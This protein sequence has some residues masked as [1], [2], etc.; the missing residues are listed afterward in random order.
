MLLPASKKTKYSKIY[1]LLNNEIEY[2]LSSCIYAN[3]FGKKLFSVGLGE[4]IYANEPSK[5]EFQGLWKVIQKCNVVERK[6]IYIK[7]K[8]SV[9]VNIYFESKTATIPDYS[10]DLFKAFSKLC[11]H[12]YSSTK[13]LVG[14][15]DIAGESISDHYLS[16]KKLNNNICLI[17]GMEELS[18]ERANI[19]D[20]EQWVSDYDHLLPV[21][22]YPFWGINPKNLWPTCKTCNQRA[23][24][25]KD[26]LFKN[27]VRRIS[28]Y[29]LDENWCSKFIKLE[30]SEGDVDSII[31]VKLDMKNEDVIINEKIN[32]WNDVYEIKNRIESRFS[33]IQDKL[34]LEVYGE[35]YLCFVNNINHKTI[36]LRDYILKKE[37][38]YWD[39]LFYSWLN[40]DKNKEVRESLW[41]S[42]NAYK[43]RTF[44]SDMIDVF[45]I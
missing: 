37:L 23:K 32:T 10:D 34:N 17:C 28:F 26:I 2:F 40:D 22:H 31:S 36:V 16:Y 19:S 12:L 1:T 30:F 11:K 3:R 33:A 41:T 5:E 7:F 44:F 39:Y 24:N 15:I 4:S 13:K 27:E 38:A 6:N 29:P 45:G 21:K 20:D 43:S 14:V 8:D 25:S 18:C 35:D 9:G 42:I